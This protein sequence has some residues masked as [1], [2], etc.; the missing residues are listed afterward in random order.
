MNPIVVLKN[1]LSIVS[2]LSLSMVLKYLNCG[3]VIAPVLDDID[4]PLYNTKV[5]GTLFA[6]ENPGLGRRGPGRK[7]DAL[8]EEEF[9]HLPKF[10]LS[11][12]QVLRMGKD[13][14]TA[15][16]LRNDYVGNCEA[17]LCLSFYLLTGLS[18]VSVT[19]LLWD[20]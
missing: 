16:K 7:T 5:Q 4:L 19:T 15:R 17:Y 14:A 11:R 9:R 18:L 12:E 20:L 3:F 1:H 13:P 6:P 2:T 10:A 8:W